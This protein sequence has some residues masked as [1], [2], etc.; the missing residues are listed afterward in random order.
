MKH[1]PILVMGDII[2]TPCIDNGIKIRENVAVPRPRAPKCCCNTINMRN[3][4]NWFIPKT[5]DRRLCFHNFE[6]PEKNPLDNMLDFLLDHGPKNVTTLALSHNG[7]KYD[8]HMVLEAL[9]KRNVKLELLMNGLKIF[10]LDCRGN[11]KR[12]IIF[13]DT[14]NYFRCK[15]ADL[16]KTFALE[17]CESKPYFPHLFTK[18]QNL[19]IKLNELPPADYYAPEWMSV[20]EHQAFQLWH[21]EEQKNP[22]QPGEPPKFHLRRDLIVYCKNDVAILRE[23]SIRYRELVKQTTGLDPFV[24]ASTVAGQALKTFRHLHLKENIMVHSPEGGLRRN[25]K[26]SVIA[27]RY[28]RLYEQIHNVQVQT[29][30]WVTGEATVEDSGYR[31]DGLVTRDP[32]QR[33]L[34]IEF[35]GCVWVCN[36]YSNIVYCI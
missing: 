12:T 31:L 14:F 15:L 30:E 19:D 25:Q 29:A 13:K 35:M 17:G 33:P 16:P 20:K 27:L 11:H 6:D 2:C 34:A 10:S 36:S 24:V 22:S 26:A 8:I 7:G 9:H 18:H 21:S 23:S 1:K 32:S 3:V 28:M 5:E 4:G